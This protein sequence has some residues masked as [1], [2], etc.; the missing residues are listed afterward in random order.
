[1]TQ[2]LTEHDLH[3]LATL[4]DGFGMTVALAGTDG[5]IQPLATPGASLVQPV[6]RQGSRVASMTLSDGRRLVLN[7]RDRAPERRPSGATLHG[8]GVGAEIG[9]AHV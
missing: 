9:R 8:H 3:A 4:L 1:M 2:G 6:P 5:R 7:E